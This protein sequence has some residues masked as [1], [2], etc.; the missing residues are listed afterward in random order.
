LLLVINLTFGIAEAAISGAVGRTHL[1]THSD[2][3]HV[4]LYRYRGDYQALADEI[5]RNA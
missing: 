2:D 1:Y 3:A 4:I 5:P